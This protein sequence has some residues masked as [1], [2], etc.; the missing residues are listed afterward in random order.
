MSQPKVYEFAK[1]LGMETIALMD[2]IKEWNLPVKSHMAA[3]TEDLVSD[4][5]DRLDAEKAPKTKKKTAKK[6][7][8]KKA[9]AKKVAKKKAVTKKVVK[10]VTTKASVEA[11]AKAVEAKPAATTKKTAARK[12]AVIRRKAAHSPEAEAAAQAEAA[13]KAA[14]LAARKAAALAGEEN[15]IAPEQ[16]EAGDQATGNLVAASE[17]EATTDESKSV[18]RAG[19]GR[20]V[21]RMDLSKVRGTTGAPAGR[22]DS[23]PPRPASSGPARGIRT[24]FVAPMP[25][26]VEP[27]QSRDS[28]RKKEDR[29]SVV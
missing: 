27:D 5:R 21:G 8:A 7:V 23:R 1:E 14:E 6:K 12:R 2:K 16:I 25:Q 26:F 19:G 15:E 20:I 3:L 4:I 13:Q 18:P 11:E 10:K 9:A 28:D 29:K 17:A 24:G 22:S